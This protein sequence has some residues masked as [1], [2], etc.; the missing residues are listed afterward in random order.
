MR[1]QTPRIARENRH[2]DDNRPCFIIIFY[3]PQVY[4]EIFVCRFLKDFN[5][6]RN[7]TIE[8][9]ICSFYVLAFLRWTQIS[10]FE[11]SLGWGGWGQS[12]F[13]IFYT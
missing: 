6:S 9:N 2:L 5:G 3:F 7:E 11:F 1:P 12:T 10:I 8:F 13:N 4:V